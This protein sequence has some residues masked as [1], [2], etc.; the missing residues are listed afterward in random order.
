MHSS[1]LFHSKLESTANTRSR[2][3]SAQTVTY[4]T[5]GSPARPAAPHSMAIWR[6]GPIR[7]LHKL[8]KIR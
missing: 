7:A 2:P 6:R 3:V 4:L 8:M 1:Q 5:S